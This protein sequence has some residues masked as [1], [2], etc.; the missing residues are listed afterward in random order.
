MKEFISFLEDYKEVLISCL[1]AILTIIAILV[2]RKPK[3]L[4]DFLL[5]I[6]EV[7]CSLPELINSVEC[8]GLGSTKKKKVEQ[9]CLNLMSSK[10]GRRLSDTEMELCLREFDS[11]IEAILSTPQK[12]GV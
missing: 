7:S 8:V 5:C 11:S 10:L 1:C 12:K 2:K 6:K 9:A 4:D 3:T